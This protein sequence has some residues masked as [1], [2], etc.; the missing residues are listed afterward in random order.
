MYDICAGD[1]KWCVV[2]CL[3]LWPKLNINMCICLFYWVI[4]SVSG[5]TCMNEVY[6][7]QRWMSEPHLNHT[8]YLSGPGTILLSQKSLNVPHQKQKSG[9]D[10]WHFKVF[11][12]LLSSFEWPQGSKGGVR[13]LSMSERKCIKLDNHSRSS[14][15]CCKTKYQVSTCGGWSNQL[16]KYTK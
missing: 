10:K 13:R 12:S 16:I 4:V 15:I 3:I 6:Q 14:S 7:A 1:F 9:A 5:R 8:K 2:Y 11:G